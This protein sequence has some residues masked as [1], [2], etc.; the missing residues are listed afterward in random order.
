MFGRILNLKTLL[1]FANIQKNKNSNMA[2]C[3]YNRKL[4]LLR[5]IWIKNQQGTR[6]RV[7]QG[8]FKRKVWFSK[9][10]FLLHSLERRMLEESSG[11]SLN[12]KEG[13]SAPWELPLFNY[14]QNIFYMQAVKWTW[15]NLI[16]YYLTEKAV[17]N[18]NL[19]ISLQ[20]L[21]V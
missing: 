9:I 11:Y 6:K 20:S 21:K 19:S 2:G 7:T 5:I 1:N 12:N 14:Q 8:N 17:P 16:K 13:A 4:F 10:T 18:T 15:K 3:T